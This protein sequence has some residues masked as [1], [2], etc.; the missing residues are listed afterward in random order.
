MTSELVALRA[1]GMFDGVSLDLIANP[2]ILLNGSTV[3]AAGES[4]PVPAGATVVDLGGATVLP[5]LIDTHVHLVF[6][7]SGTVTVGDRSW[8]VTRGDLFVVP[9]WQAFD[10]RSEAGASDSD[11]G[12]LDLFRFSDAPVFEA[13]QL[14]R[15]QVERTP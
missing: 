13:L 5:G 3:L 4:L 9:S 11:S 8:A 12:A 2:T 14:N 7:G 6:D 1:A 10:A 15:V